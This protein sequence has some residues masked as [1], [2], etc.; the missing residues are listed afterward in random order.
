M[1]RQRSTAKAAAFPIAVWQWC[2]AD[3][4]VAAGRANV[5]PRRASGKR[6]GGG[7]GGGETL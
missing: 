6:L 5:V 1:A 7:G 3:M 4:L 2:G